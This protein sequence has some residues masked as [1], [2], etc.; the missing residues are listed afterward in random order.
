MNLQMIS[1]DLILN[2]A[3]YINDP[4]D[5]L[6]LRNATEQFRLFLQKSFILHQ[7]DFLFYDSVILRDLCKSELRLSIRGPFSHTVLQK[8]MGLPFPELLVD[9]LQSLDHGS[10]SHDN[11]VDIMFHATHIDR[12]DLIDLVRSHCFSSVEFKAAL[13]CLRGYDT[14]L[15]SAIACRSLKVVR[16][17]INLG[18]DVNEI[19]GGSIS[20][21][22]VAL[23]GGDVKILEFLLRVAK[24]RVI[25]GHAT[26]DEVLNSQIL[27]ILP[28]VTQMFL[29]KHFG[30]LRV[31]T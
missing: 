17:L 16:T 2:I 1:S 22:S 28:H 12:P 24:A 10:L 11:V 3:S 25:P 5:Y 6:Q 14:L 23:W 29:R 31:K 4:M 27:F 8:I 21:L 9:Y 18:F 20:P 13:R 19:V 26:L 15:T 7:S 30:Q